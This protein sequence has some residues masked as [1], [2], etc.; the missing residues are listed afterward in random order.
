MAKALFFLFAFLFF[1]SCSTSQKK[2]TEETKEEAPE[3]VTFVMVG[4]VR[5]CLPEIDSMAESYTDSLVKVFADKH[6]MKGNSVLAFYLHNPTRFYVT[7]EGEKIYDDFFKIYTVDNLKDLNIDEKYLDDV[8]TS[9]SDKN[10]VQTW[11][12]VQKKLEKGF[13][14]VPLDQ[15]YFIDQY[16]PHPKVRSFVTLYRYNTGNYETLLLGI[17]NIM[18]IKERL[19]GMTYYKAFTGQDILSKTRTINDAIISKIMAENGL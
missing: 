15:P 9:I 10:P 14:F 18:L 6:E 16:S 3:C 4:Q 17:M 19:V 2:S 5:I 11:G 8:A 1:L 12:I 13:D 7:R